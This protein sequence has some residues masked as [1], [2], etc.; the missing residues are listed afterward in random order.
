MG[1][2]SIGLAAG[3]AM[4]LAALPASGEGFGVRRT[5]Q[6]EAA[7]W[8]AV[9]RLT[10]G[11]QFACTATLI[12]TDLVLTA[13]HCVLDGE[14]GPRP[15]RHFIF[16]AGWR[17][18]AARVER[19][20]ASIA[21][22]PAYVLEPEP[23][24]E[25]VASDIALLTLASAIDAGEIEPIGAAD[26]PDWARDVTIASYGRDREEVLSVEESCSVEA[27]EEDILAL[28]CDVTFGSSG[29]PV[30]LRRP[31]GWRRVVGVVSARGGAGE[32]RA[33]AARTDVALTPLMD[34]GARP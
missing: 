28:L 21:V 18:G 15:A 20:V 33:F 4:V 13:A 9:G 29:A 10:L 19:R 24:R 34:H 30:I 25:Q 12:A 1:G 6:S 14:H 31:G 23:R 2:W 11:G 5:F 7:Q 22:N 26:M 8:A 16:Q 17:D 32:A 3:A 27:A